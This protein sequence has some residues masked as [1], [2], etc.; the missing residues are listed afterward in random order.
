MSHEGRYPSTLP[1]PLGFL[2]VGLQIHRGDVGFRGLSVS[3]LWTLKLRRCRK[4]G[5]MRKGYRRR[6]DRRRG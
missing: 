5:Y 4:K 2:F 1:G 6:E 3:I